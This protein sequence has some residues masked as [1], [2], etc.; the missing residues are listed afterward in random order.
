MPLFQIIIV[1]GNDGYLHIYTSVIY[2][3][4]THAFIRIPKILRKLYTV[5]RLC[6]YIICKTIEKAVNVIYQFDTMDGREFL[7]I[8]EVRSYIG[9]TAIAQK[10]GLSVF[11]LFISNEFQTLNLLRL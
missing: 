8:I 10:P 5:V 6:T 9:L 3:K 7:K 1:I 2:A 4:K 11:Y